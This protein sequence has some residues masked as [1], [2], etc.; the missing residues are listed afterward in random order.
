[1]TP[2]PTTTVASTADIR[3]CFPAL[4]RVHNDFPVAYFDGPGGTQV[5]SHVVE[6]M[7]DYLY[8]HNAN[9][10]WAY[11]TSAETDAAIENARE[12]CA[13]FLNAS[14]REIAFGA[15]MT[16]LTF[17][18]ARTLGAQYGPDDEIIVTELDHHANV[19]PWRR[20]TIE[21]GVEVKTVKMITETGQL[22]WNDFEDAVTNRTKLVAI[23]AASN[24]LGTINDL[25]RATSLA[26][27]VGSLV[28]VDAVHYAPHSLVDVREL[29]CD[30]LAMSAYKFY[31][32]HIGVLFGKLALLES[33]D[34][35]KLEPAPDYAPENA[36]TGTQNQEGMVGAG[37]AIDF[38]ASL[39][40][41][42]SIKETRRARLSEV[43]A[44]LHARNSQLTGRLWNGLSSIEGVRLYGPPPEKARTP[45]ISF[46]VDGVTSTD[47]ARRLGERGLFLSHGDFYAA[48]I[49]ERLG[50][51]EEGM[52]RAGCACYTTAEEI[53]RLIEGVA[54]I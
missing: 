23:G 17:H 21:R 5:P 12:V 11:P 14:P 36:E 48:T 30:F 19:A 9:T 54:D 32:P 45:T 13:E 24:A 22:D 27:S 37:A 20:L 18:L 3:A 25:A 1:M 51:G 46:T 35:P 10:H 6:A 38:L 8:H 41:A 42:E 33:L 4:S 26:R 39:A 29:D 52:V 40:N 47:V 43:Y 2:Q 49:P 53:E 28:F 34:F 50:L 7:S 15:N 16:T 44:E 31:G